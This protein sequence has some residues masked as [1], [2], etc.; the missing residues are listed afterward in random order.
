MYFIYTIHF[1]V[2]FST[3]SLQSSN[4]I[5]YVFFFSFAEKKK[6]ACLLRLSSI[7][8][9]KSSYQTANFFHF[10]LIEET[11]FVH[12]NIKNMLK[13]LISITPFY[14][15]STNNYNYS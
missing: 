7:K 9:K 15:S 10:I 4:V 13:L 14:K 6:C 11:S 1:A 2:G 5:I 8:E 12:L 3:S